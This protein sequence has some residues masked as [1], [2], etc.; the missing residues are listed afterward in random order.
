M[1]RTKGEREIIGWE[2]G[3]VFLN[4]AFNGNEGLS[5]IGEAQDH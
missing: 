2:D 1:N 3:S 4:N 5:G